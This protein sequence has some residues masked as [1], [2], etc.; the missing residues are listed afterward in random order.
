MEDKRYYL[1]QNLYLKGKEN[2]EM[3]PKIKSI[4]FPFN[5]SNIFSV[6]G[7]VLVLGR[8]FT[9]CLAVLVFRILTV[10][11]REELYYAIRFILRL[12]VFL[13]EHQKNL[14][15]YLFK[16]TPRIPKY[17]LICSSLREGQIHLHQKKRERERENSELSLNFLLYFNPTIP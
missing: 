15:I 4:L 8:S 11:Y 16:S 12:I 5:A 6:Y 3:F 17:I 10:M 2:G 13:S 14:K 1:H 7:F 9:F